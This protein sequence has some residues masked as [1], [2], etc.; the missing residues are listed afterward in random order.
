MLINHQTTNLIRGPRA[1]KQIPR[2]LKWGVGMAAVTLLLWF[3]QPIWEFVR[4][5][6]DREAVIAYLEQFGIV[7]PLLLALILVLQVISMQKGML[8]FLFAFMVPIFPADVMNY[9]AGLSALSGRRFFV[10]NLLG[11]LPGVVLMTAVGAYGFQFSLTIWLVV[12]LASVG[13][14]LF[15]RTLFVRNRGR[16]R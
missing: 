9:V 2:W 15:W 14:F 11:R 10:A 4:I 3:W 1:T 16:V 6:A 8:F 5:V 7:G 13:M 12:G